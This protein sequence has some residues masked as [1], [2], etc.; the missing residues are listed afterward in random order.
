MIRRTIIIQNSFRPVTIVQ[1]ISQTAFGIL[2][3]C[4]VAILCKGQSAA[5]A[6]TTQ[7]HQNGYRNERFAI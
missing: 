2:Y 4:L 5:G 1:V 3:L 6:G 7:I